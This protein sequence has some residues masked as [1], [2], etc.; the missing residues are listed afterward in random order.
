MS[1]S[2]RIEL[3]IFGSGGLQK[4]TSMWFN[5]HLVVLPIG[6]RVDGNKYFSVLPSSGE[7]GES[8]HSSA[9]GKVSN[10]YF[11]IDGKLFHSTSHLCIGVKI[12]LFVLMPHIL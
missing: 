10:I 6:I 9:Q 2:M 1:L 7:L 11:N 8:S 3:R 4:K 12:S 5:N